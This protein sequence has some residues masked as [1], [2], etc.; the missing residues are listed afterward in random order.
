[1][2]MEKVL[3]ACNEC[4]TDLNAW[5]EL[6]RFLQR[7]GSEEGPL[8]TF[9]KKTY[10][11]IKHFQTLSG[12]SSVLAPLIE[13]GFI[14][15]RPELSSPFTY[16][17]KPGKIFHIGRVPVSDT[18]ILYLNFEALTQLKANLVE[19]PLLEEYHADARYLCGTTSFLHFDSFQEDKYSNSPE[20][21][22]CAKCIAT[23]TSES[24]RRGKPWFWQKGETPISLEEFNQLFSFRQ[25]FLR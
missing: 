9:V 2:S 24:S 14:F 8:F 7:G 3:F 25:S 17:T 23:L 5:G 22:P 12:P 21:A 10:D 18:E 11:N 19:D 1:M 15:Y 16:V 6:Y 20:C 4:P 13:K